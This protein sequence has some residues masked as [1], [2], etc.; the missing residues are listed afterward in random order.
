MVSLFSLSLEISFDY[1]LLTQTRHTLAFLREILAAARP[2]HRHSRSACPHGLSFVRRLVGSGP[3]QADRLLPTNGSQVASRLHRTRIGRSARQSRGTSCSG[4]IVVPS[5][6]HEFA[7]TCSVAS[8]PCHRSD[9][10]RNSTPAQPHPVAA[11]TRSRARL[12]LVSL[13]ALQTGISQTE[14]L[15]KTWCNPSS[16]STTTVVVVKPIRITCYNRRY[17]QTTNQETRTAANAE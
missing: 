12:A 14:P 13:S 10:A 5:F 1:C 17:E 7:T 15:S 3:G 11:T 4:G 2:C 16:L 6:R 9:R 8:C